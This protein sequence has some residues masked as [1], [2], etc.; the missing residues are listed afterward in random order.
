[1]KHDVAF[2]LHARPPRGSLRRG[3]HRMR[4]TGRRQPGSN[5]SDVPARPEVQTT[6]HPQQRNPGRRL[7]LAPEFER[8]A[9]QGHVQPVAVGTPDDPR[10]PVRGTKRVP[11]GELFQQHHRPAAP[12]ERPRR[13][14]AGETG[15]DDHDV[16]VKGHEAKA[17]VGS[18]D[19]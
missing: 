19:F 14:G 13:R 15:T 11:A 3:Q 12:R 16:R 5:P 18:R 8:L 9:S 6:Q 7:H 10:R 2:E 4:N 17:I 1:M